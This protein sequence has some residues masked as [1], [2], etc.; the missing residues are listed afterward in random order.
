MLYNFEWDPAKASSNAEKHGVTFEQAT[1]IFQDPMALTLYDEDNTSSNE[2]R[3]VTLGKV[4]GEYY[5]VVAHTYHDF[6]HHT[7]IIRLISARPATKREIAQH[8]G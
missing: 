8:Q 5:L 7:V 1:G 6:P 4:N 2:D 3:W